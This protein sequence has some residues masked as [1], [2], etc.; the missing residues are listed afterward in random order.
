VR[1]YVSRFKGRVKYWEI[2]NEPNFSMSPDQYVAMV[3][4]LT[5]LIKSIDP[6]AQVMGPTV[7][8]IQLPWHQAF[9]A[10]GGGPYVDILSVHDYEGH[11]SI[12]E[13]HWRWKF[14]ELR[15]IMAQYGDANKPIWQTERAV[16][17]VRGGNFMGLTQAI[18]TT[19][20]RDVLETLGVAPEHNSL[21]YMNQGG[22]TEVPS[23]LWSDSGP[24]A[25]IMA[26]RTRHAQTQARGRSYAGTLDFGPDGNKIF[27]GLRY[28]GGDGSTIVLRNLGT[29][30]QW[31]KVAVSGGSSLQVMDAFGNIQS[32]AVQNGQAELSVTQMPQ[33][34][35]LSP[36]QNVTAPQISLGTNI[37]AQASFSYTGESRG[38]MSLLNNGV[39]EVFH[40]NVAFGGTDGGAIWTGGLTVGSNGVPTPQAL[41]M[42]FER[43]YDI[44]KL[45]IRS[46]RADNQFSSL[47]DYDLEYWSSGRWQSLESMRTPM[48]ASDWV[49]N[50][51]TLVNTWHADT[52][53]FVHQFTPVTTDKIR[54]IPRRT[55]FGFSAD[56]AAAAATQR[57]WGGHREPSLMLRE[58]EVY[59]APMSGTAPVIGNGDGL[60]GTYY[61]NQDFSG[62]SISRVDRQINFNWSNGSPDAAIAADSW[63][64]RWTGQVQAQ[65]DQTYTFHTRS[66]DGV[67]LWVNGQLL[68]DQWKGQSPTE[69]SGSIDLKA[70]QRYDIKLEYL[71]VMG[72][73]EVQL[74]WSS[75]W[76]PRQ[77]IPQSQLYSTTAPISD[78]PAPVPTPTP[79]PSPTPAPGGTVVGTG[80]G[81]AAIY[82]DNQDFS[83][84]SISRV[85][86]Q[87]NFDW[88]NGSPD[89]AIAPD[90]F[91]AR[92]TG[93]VQA[94]KSETYTFYAQAD[95]GVRLW[96]NGQ[97]LADG[98]KNQ[99]PTE[100][101]GSIALGS[102]SEV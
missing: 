60:Q 65:Y 87:V 75:P 26:L 36:G 64:T 66:D 31:L 5:P 16:G 12:D 20:H 77:L 4:Q 23:Y 67:R 37:A 35:L 44:S 98:W 32:V 18:R 25:A 70:G 59:G 47:L 55:T 38:N 28:N 81:L 78:V 76:T 88:G 1:A 96:V 8:G 27:L 57:T 91:S 84:K 42:T 10:L 85:D 86:P 97:L 17:G 2:M 100:Y 29:V 43:P 3:K 11:E 69:Y 93:Q 48:P 33:Y 99:G 102:G 51:E 49:T 62:K 50:A 58:I 52:N 101:S 46:V 82:Y 22:Y 54:L 92:W 74:S 14:A 9:Y 56:A 90:T 40:D 95:D 79:I 15:K 41:Q 68:I 83:G 89:A 7:C 6:A 61:D 21:Y 63:S 72:A 71:E 30:E 53:F 13:V 80:S 73:A 34:L 24:H 94:Q 19:L 45:L 39:T